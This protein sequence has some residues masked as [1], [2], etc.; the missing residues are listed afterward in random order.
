MRR[1]EVAEVCNLALR[2]FQEFVAPQFSPEGVRQFRNH[3]DPHLF[4]L[5]SQ[6]KNFILIAADKAADKGEVVGMIETSY[7]GH[8]NLFFVDGRFQCQGIGGEL[9]KKALEICRMRN[10]EM[11]TVT[12][13]SAPSAVGIYERLGFRLAG[14]ESSVDQIRSVPMILE[15]SDADRQ[16]AR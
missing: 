8:V 14:P 6:S 9:L 13:N 5:R 11:S 1:G 12:V 4:L 7:D 3:T 10:P 2:V 15:I 16:P